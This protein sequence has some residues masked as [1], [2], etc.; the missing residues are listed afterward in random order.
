MGDVYLAQDKSLNRYVAIKIL[1]RE[2]TSDAERLGRFRREAQ[3]ASILN[4]PNILTIFDQGT[5]ANLIVPA[6]AAAASGELLSLEVNRDGVTDT[7][8]EALQVYGIL[9]RYQADRA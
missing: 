5:Y 7:C 3:V 9:V 1:P 4:H 2:Y 8:A 6:G